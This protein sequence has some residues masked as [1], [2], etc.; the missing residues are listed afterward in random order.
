MSLATGCCAPCETPDVVEVPGVQGDDGADGSDGADGISSFSLLTATATVP[1]LAGDAVALQVAENSWAAVGQVLFTSDGTDR[2]TVRVTGLTGSTIISTVWLDAPNDSAPGSIVGIGGKVTPSGETGE[3]AAALPTAFTDNSGGTASNS[4]AVGVGIYT[5][6]H[7]LTS[8][9]TGLGVL[10]ID[11]LTGLTIGHRFQLLSFD[12]VTT[13]VGAGAGAS[14]VFNLE[15]GGTDVTGGVLT[16]D[17]ASTNT[18]G[19]ISAG[20]AITADNVG[21]AGGTISIEMAAGGTVFTSGSGYFVI[22][23]K[24]LDSSDAFASLA[25][26]VNDLITALT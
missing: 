2:M 5:L 16:V 4:I 8:L 14:Q 24:N 23:I 20:T 9:A 6:V 17:L 12:F 1:A 18:I 15:I 3:L 10:A 13:I 11:L 22:R 19:E 7:P 21:T 25:D 26:H